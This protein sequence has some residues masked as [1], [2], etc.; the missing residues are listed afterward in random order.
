MIYKIITY[1]IIIDDGTY[2]TSFL[3]SS[4]IKNLLRFLS[5]VVVAALAS[6]LES[7]FNYSLLS[8]VEPSLGDFVGILVLS[9]L[10][11]TG[12][13][14]QESISSFF[15]IKLIK[16]KKKKIYLLYFLIK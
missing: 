13:K 6:S 3:S 16:K 10:I 1:I 2:L 14:T 5:F 8:L 4:S 7:F 15:L 12:A 11:F 9:Y